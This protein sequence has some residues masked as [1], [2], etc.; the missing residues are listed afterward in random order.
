[1][2][3]IC[4]LRA[5]NGEAGTHCDGDECSF[6]RVAGPVA[7]GPGSGCAIKYYQLLGDESVAA[8]LLSVKERLDCVRQD[9]RVSPAGSQER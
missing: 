5:A 9:D 7:E 3:D 8:W 2:D 4:D 1:M 6:W